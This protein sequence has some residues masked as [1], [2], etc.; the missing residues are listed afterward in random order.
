MHHHAKTI[1]I[2]HMGKG[3][4]FLNHLAVDAVHVFLAAIDLGRNAGLG[5]GALDRFENSID[6]LAAVA[7]RLFDRA[8]DDGEAVRIKIGETQILQLAVDLIEA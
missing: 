4:F 6:A 7:A 1:D 3:E 8:R 5:Q 2:E